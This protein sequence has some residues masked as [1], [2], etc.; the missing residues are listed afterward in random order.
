VVL[1]ELEHAKRRGVRILAEIV[2]YG[3]TGDAYH[4]T[5]PAP[6]GEGAGRAMRAAIR[7]S[8]LRSSRSDI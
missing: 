1:E 2:G 8:G 7:N 5:A 6:E 3:A 4:M